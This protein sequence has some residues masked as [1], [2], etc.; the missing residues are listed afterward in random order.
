MSVIDLGQGLPEK[1]TVRFTAEVTYPVRIGG[2][3]RV[4]Q[5]VFCRVDIILP[6]NSDITNTQLAALLVERYDLPKGTSVRVAI[7]IDLNQRFCDSISIAGKTLTFIM[8]CEPLE[9]PKI[10]VTEYHAVSWNKS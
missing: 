9:T 6:K 4:R 3:A 8:E 5:I 2:T 1:E 7:P 10:P